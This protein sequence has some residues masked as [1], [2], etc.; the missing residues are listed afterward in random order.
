MAHSHISVPFN[1]FPP[2]SPTPPSPPK[3][4]PGKGLYPGFLHDS[5]AIALEVDIAD[6]ELAGNVFVVGILA[7]EADDAEFGGLL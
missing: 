1:T 5:S 4:Q 7:H 2:T 6:N 3:H